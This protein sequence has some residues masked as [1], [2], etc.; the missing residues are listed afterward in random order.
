MT[1][2]QPPVLRIFFATEMWERYGFYVVQ[3]LLA[4]YLALHFQ[5]PDH[6][7]YILVSSFTALTYLSPLLGG[8]IA[9]HLLGQKT[10]IIL[11]S[12]TLFSSY[13]FLSSVYSQH[14][15]CLALS[16]I[17]VGNGLLKPNISSLL[18]NAYP[19]NSPN[20]ENGF[21]I[22]YI[23][24]TIGIILGTTLPSIISQ[25]FGW[26]AAFISAALGMVIA[27]SVFVF[28]IFRYAINDYQESEHNFKNTLIAITLMVGM[29]FA[30]MY[31]LT[32][33]HI[34]DIAVLSVVVGAFVYFV[35]CALRESPA[36]ARRTVVLGIL[37]VIS[38]LFW[39]F[40]F[41]MFTSLTLF[42]LRTVKPTLFGFSFPPPY[43]VGLQSFGMIVFGIIMS[44]A[45]KQYDTVTQQIVH[46]SNKFVMSMLCLTVSYGL[47]VWI[48][49]A[50]NNNA[51]ISPGY[52]I[53]A[54]LVISMAELL[55][56]PV[57]L[58]AVTILS[59]RKTVSTMM[60]IFFVSLGV[61]A[62]L[63]GKLA[64]LTSIDTDQLLATNIKSH[65]AGSFTTIFYILIAASALAA[66]LNF[67]VQ[68]LLRQAEQSVMDDHL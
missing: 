11:G 19:E 62:Y 52:L 65:Y 8:W 30:S 56:S 63:S 45:P 55:L 13:L 32:S 54:Y 59:S 49:V 29:W 33:P 20:R 25:H 36:Q 41:Q 10:S 40:Y 15:L 61:G 67:L 22:F 37:C 5:W 46:A 48:S 43:Y 4:L 26:P 35:R 57:G 23:G 66:V 39:A 16:G 68:V 60:G 21:M 38:V 7:I 17:V 2:A 14:S 27:L 12:I 53:P 6:Q 44:R 28:G 18:G 47:I 58:S 50:N 1:F 51:L 31:I 3:T 42:I 24:L 64:G 9:D 34:A